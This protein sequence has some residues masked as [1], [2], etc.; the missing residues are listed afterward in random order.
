LWDM[1]DMG[2]GGGTIPSSPPSWGPMHF[3]FAKT[4]AIKEDV[5]S[6]RM[7]PLPW[8][9]EPY[10]RRYSLI[11][12]QFTTIQLAI[13]AKKCQA[14]LSLAQVACIQTSA[15]S[16]H[17]IHGFLK[18]CRKI[19]GSTAQV[20]IGPHLGHESPAEECSRW[21]CFC[22]LCSRHRVPS[23]SSKSRMLPYPRT[24]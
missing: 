1:T 2:G 3:F 9:S 23:S 13:I 18:P 16:S 11:T 17:I 24:C 15:S 19:L 8:Q 4:T 5:A 22:L 6:F 20:T 10:L 21:R 12:M 7:N 14:K